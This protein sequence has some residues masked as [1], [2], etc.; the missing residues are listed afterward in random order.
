M[1]KE[2]S[3]LPMIMGIIGGAL[4]VPAAFCSGVCGAIGEEFG[5]AASGTTDLFM[6][7]GLIGALIGLAGG[8]ISKKKPTVSGILMITATFM[9]GFTLVYG[10]MLALAVAVLF[11]I[12]GI[13]CFVQKKAE[14]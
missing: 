7:V 1:K 3:N 2:V 11:L 14:A 8:L 9:A 6:W 10:N 4:G 12:G 5:D 13:F